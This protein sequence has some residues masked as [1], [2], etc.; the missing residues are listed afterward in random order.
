MRR[1]RFRYGLIVIFRSDAWWLFPG[2][3]SPRV[4]PS[5]LC[6]HRVF[7]VWFVTKLLPAFDFNMIV[8]FTPPPICCDPLSVS[9]CPCVQAL[10]EWHLLNHSTVWN[11][12]WYVGASPWFGMSCEKLG[13]LSSRSRS[14][15]GLRWSKYDC[16]YYILIADLFPARLSMWYIINRKIQGAD[17]LLC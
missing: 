4:L 6:S 17:G 3:R 8:I 16:F 7:S 1:L 13:L 14:Q 5:S 11:Q 2:N 15:W 10:S 9:V 12:I